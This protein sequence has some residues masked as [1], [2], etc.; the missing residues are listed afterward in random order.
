MTTEQFDSFTETGEW[1]VKRADELLKRAKQSFIAGKPI[2]H[3]EY[4]EFAGR[5]TQW[6]KDFERFS[7]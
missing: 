2:N 7:E 5:M 1:L 3:H 6:K 4:K